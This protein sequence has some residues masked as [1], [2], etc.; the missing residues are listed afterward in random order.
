MLNFFV[1]VAN[2]YA[3]IIYLITSVDIS[4]TIYYNNAINTVR[5]VY[6]TLILIFLEYGFFI[7]P[8]KLIS[9][10]ITTMYL[11]LVVVGGVSNTSDRLYLLSES[12]VIATFYVLFQGSEA[13]WNFKRELFTGIKQVETL[14]KYYVKSDQ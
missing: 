14:S 8:S 1:N 4:P 9:H 6:T 12:I 3:M 2:Y 11:I 10:T 13:L 5:T 7:R